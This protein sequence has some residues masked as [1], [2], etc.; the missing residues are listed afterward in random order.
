MLIAIW[1]PRS[2]TSQRPAGG[3]LL[4]QKN[5]FIT[6]K[7]QLGRDKAILVAQSSL[8]WAVFLMLIRDVGCGSKLRVMAVLGLAD[9]VYQ[10][11]GE[12]MGFMRK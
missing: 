1:L 7:Y 10:E 3:L 2:C 12:F 5:V 9:L 4:L 6:Q 8:T 11:R